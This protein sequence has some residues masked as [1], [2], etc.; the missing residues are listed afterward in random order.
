LERFKASSVINSFLKK[1]DEYS[2]S[3]TG[4]P[5]NITSNI[6]ILPSLFTTLSENLQHIEY[7]RKLL[8]S[9]DSKISELEFEVSKAQKAKSK[10]KEI[11]KFYWQRVQQ[12]E[13]E[14]ENQILN[15]KQK[16]VQL[17]N[18][19][20]VNEKLISNLELE[21]K[22]LR[23]ENAALS[24]S[25]SNYYTSLKLIQDSK[26][27]KVLSKYWHLKGRILDKFIGAKKSK[28]V[29]RLA[30]SLIKN[31]SQPVWFLNCPL[32]D[33][34]IPL[35]Q[36]PHHIAI[37]LSKLGSVY[38]YSTTNTYDE[39]E[40]IER[41]SE[42]CY[43]TNRFNELDSFNINGKRKV[44]HIHAADHNIDISFLEKRLDQGHMVL[45]EYM[46]EIHPDLIGPVYEKII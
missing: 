39:V 33:W 19:K 43:L 44:Y 8:S 16:V 15:L 6:D 26:A 25:L 10:L 14:K 32:V 38:F 9:K 5:V 29:K 46:D 13:K 12:L 34:N 45:Y 2:Q 30:T 37:N 20:Q 31:S 4:Y 1:I 23:E 36:R 27:W 24:S 7:A 41:I 28:E 40:G 22:A 3:F 42:N 11:L 18:E 17:E 35:F 21:I